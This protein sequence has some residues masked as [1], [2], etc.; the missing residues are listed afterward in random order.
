MGRIGS[1]DRLAL[2]EAMQSVP[3]KTSIWRLSLLSEFDVDEAQ[4]KRVTQP[5]LLIAG[6]ADRLLPSFNEAERLVSIFPNA[7]M[8]ILPDSGHA[9]LLEAD[10]NLYKIMQAQHFLDNREDSSVMV[11]P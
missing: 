11:L 2:L 10:V 6:D 8:C 3:Q 7:Q 4:L 1:S 9:C 5:V